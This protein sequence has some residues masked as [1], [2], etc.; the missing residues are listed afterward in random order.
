[1]TSIG[2]LICEHEAK[3]RN[4]YPCHGYVSWVRSVTYV[5]GLDN[6]PDGGEGV[7]RRRMKRSSLQIL[8]VLTRF[9]IRYYIHSILCRQFESPSLRQPV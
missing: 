1:M 6:G 5:S 4:G 3:T 8:T 2:C 7:R 9:Y